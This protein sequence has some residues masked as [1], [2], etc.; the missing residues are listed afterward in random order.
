MHSFCFLNRQSLTL[1]KP[2]T[3]RDLTCWVF[4]L[5]VHKV[6]EMSWYTDHVLVRLHLKQQHPAE[7]CRQTDLHVN[8]QYSMSSKLTHLD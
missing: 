8:Q 7:Q 3:S 4:D 5:M 1:Q 2:E 6:S